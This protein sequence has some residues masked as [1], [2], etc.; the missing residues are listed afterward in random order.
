MKRPKLVVSKV[1]KGQPN[2][3][4]NKAVRRLA[5]GLTGLISTGKCNRVY[6]LGQDIIARLLWGPC[7]PSFTA[8]ALVGTCSVEFHGFQFADGHLFTAGD[9][10]DALS[11]QR[12]NPPMKTTK[13]VTASLL[14]H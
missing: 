3:R 6:F 8:L 1:V 14:D 13:Y 9:L 11:T 4:G 12:S 5:V 7:H 10:Q 2:L